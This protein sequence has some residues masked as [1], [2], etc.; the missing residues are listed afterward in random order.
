MYLV[1]KQPIE[2][3]IRIKNEKQLSMRFLKFYLFFAA[4]L[5]LHRVKYWIRNRTFSFYFLPMSL[6]TILENFL[7]LVFTV[8]N[9]L[10]K[11]GQSIYQRMNW[12]KDFRKEK[13]C[14]LFYKI[15]HFLIIIRIW[16]TRTYEWRQNEMDIH[17]ILT[18]NQCI[19]KIFSLR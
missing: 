4:E 10:I 13:Y 17:L 14:T 5:V 19:N 6:A 9:I 2:S 11:K 3:P 12:K 7:L 18:Q 8:N 16:W 1:Q 15:I